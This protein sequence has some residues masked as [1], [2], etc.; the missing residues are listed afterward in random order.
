MD[1]MTEVM[2]YMYDGSCRI[3]QIIRPKDVCLKP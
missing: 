3:L 2:N 1:N